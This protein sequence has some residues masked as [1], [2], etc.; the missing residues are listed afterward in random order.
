MITEA[1]KL[2]AQHS[3]VCA[4][5]I[6]IFKKRTCPTFQLGGRE[7]NISL[8]LFKYQFYISGSETRLSGKIMFFSG[9]TGKVLR[10]SGVPDVRESYYSPVIYKWKDGTQVVLFGTGGET[11]PGSLYYITLHDLY[12]GKIDRVS[13]R[14]RG[15]GR[16]MMREMEGGR[17]G[18]E[19]CILD[20]CTTLHQRR[21]V[22]RRGK[23]HEEG[24]R[25]EMEDGGIEEG[26]GA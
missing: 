11:H 19:I 7:I 21:E 15:G 13:R 9:R 12:K 26:E 16:R 20:H 4:F 17:M 14:E 8:S 10:W 5:V 3:H 24:R 18:R 23:E 25:M 22:E 2:Y 6:H 1:Q